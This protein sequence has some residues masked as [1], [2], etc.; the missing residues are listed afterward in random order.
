MRCCLDQQ[1]CWSLYE[2]IY[3]SAHGID[4]G[5]RWAQLL[6]HARTWVNN[7]GSQLHKRPTQ[8]TSQETHAVH[9]FGSTLQAEALRVGKP[10]AKAFPHKDFV[11]RYLKDCTVQQLM[12]DAE[13]LRG[14]LTAAQQ[15]KLLVQRLVMCCLSCIIAAIVL[16]H[17]LQAVP[18]YCVKGTCDGHQSRCWGLMLATGSRGVVYSIVMN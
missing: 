16:L 2:H 3:I 1:P 18:M 8:C 5:V 11:Q 13:F 14:K 17:V 4:G 7:V 6:R 9:H 15:V 10:D 12:N